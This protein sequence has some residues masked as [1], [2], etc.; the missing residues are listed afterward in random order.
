MGQQKTELTE[1]LIVR[2]GHENVVCSE[3]NGGVGVGDGVSVAASDVTPILALSTFVAAC[4]TF[5]FGCAV[6]AFLLIFFNSLKLLENSPKTQ[7]FFSLIALQI[8]FSSPTQSSVMEELGISV[9][10]VKKP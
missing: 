1:S 9:A 3:E 6:S 8:G 4:T 10:E 2:H 7:L 5:G